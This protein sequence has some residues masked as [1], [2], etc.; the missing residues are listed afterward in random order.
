MQ[1]PLPRPPRVRD[2][3]L[4][5]PLRLLDKLPVQIDRVP[6]HAAH[7]VVLPEDVVRRLP[8]VL[9]R[10]GAV[11]LALLGQLVRRAAVAAL[12]GLVRLRWGLARGLGGWRVVCREGRER[13]SMYV[14]MYIRKTW[15]RPL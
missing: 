1:M 10:Q 14:C 5:Y 11:A 2:P 7:G 3:L 13:A 15:L 9:V 12:V 6:V 4:Q 8:V